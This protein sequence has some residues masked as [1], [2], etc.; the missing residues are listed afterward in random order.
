LEKAE[1]FE[2][3]DGGVICMVDAPRPIGER[4]CAIPS[5]II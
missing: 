1:G 3:S 5:N 2:V 4:F